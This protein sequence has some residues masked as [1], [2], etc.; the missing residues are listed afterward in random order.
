MA[1]IEELQD[2]QKE[3]L[4]KIRE[5][6]CEKDRDII[7]ASYWWGI[8]PFIGTLQT[9]SSEDARAIMEQIMITGE[10]IK[11]HLNKTV[12]EEKEKEV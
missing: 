12:E 4:D 2:F 6:M 10:N 8:V 11:K 3:K 9:D 7:L 5:L 1:T